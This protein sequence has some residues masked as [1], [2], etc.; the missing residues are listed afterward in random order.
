MSD[1]VFFFFMYGVVMS[2]F[3]DTDA[4]GDLNEI[5]LKRKNWE[6]FIGR[7]YSLPYYRYLP[8]RLKDEL[9]RSASITANSEVGI[10][11]VDEATND[12]LQRRLDFIK[13]DQFFNSE[14]FKVFEL[15][16]DTDDLA[17]LI[18]R[19]CKNDKARFVP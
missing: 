13:S 5:R 11:S 1:D 17:A 3:C 15:L 7:L 16:N 2:I 10:Y 18:K 9:R 8:K 4:F 14:C 12:Q 19:Y 6:A